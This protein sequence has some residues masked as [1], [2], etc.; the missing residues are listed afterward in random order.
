MLDNAEVVIKSKNGDIS[1]TEEYTFY[2][3]DNVLWLDTYVVKKKEGRKT[4]SVEYY[5]RLR[6]QNS[7]IKEK[8]V[9]L[10]DE[11]KK[12]AI[13]NFINKLSVKKWYERKRQ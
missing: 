10:T 8:D 3:N 9:P 13:E 1:V 5:D 11:I 2:L 12:E 6:E 4:I 7:N